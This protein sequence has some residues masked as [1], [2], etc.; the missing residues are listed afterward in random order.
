MFRKATLL[1]AAMTLVALPLFAGEKR[2]EKAR[3]AIDGLRTLNID[4]PVG[5]LEVRGGDVKEVVAQL[6]VSCKG[7]SCP[8]KAEDVRIESKRIGGELRLEVDGF[9]KHGRGVEAELVVTVPRNV[10]VEVDHGVGEV[11]ISGMTA[12][13]EVD[14]GVGEVR[15][16]GTAASFREANAE[17]GVGDVDLTVKG[18]HVKSES[19]F[20]GNTVEWSGGAGGSRIDLELGVGSAEIDLD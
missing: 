9:P 11:T 20:V 1:V 6:T 18:R 14:A 8:E 2:T 3:F 17:S 10:A 4:H 5:T 12:D 15:I 19:H 16:S 13:I 7:F